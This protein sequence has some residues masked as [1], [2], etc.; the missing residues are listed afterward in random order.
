MRPGVRSYKKKT[1]PGLATRRRSI[2]RA[3]PRWAGPAAQSHFPPEVRAGGTARPTPAR[4]TPEK[5]TW[6]SGFFGQNR[7][8]VYSSRLSPALTYGYNPQLPGQVD[9]ETLVGVAPS[10]QF[11]AGSN[12]LDQIMYVHYL[13]PILTKSRDFQPAQDTGRRLPVT[14][15]AV[16]MRGRI[17]A[18]GA[19]QTVPQSRST[20]VRPSIQR[21]PHRRGISDSAKRNRRGGPR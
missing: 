5:R 18:P 19:R 4:Q 13:Q 6:T 15:K 10:T 12:N 20:L 21:T 11:K 1:P 9:F 3:G 17:Q 7:H 8:T 14:L 2:V 16:P